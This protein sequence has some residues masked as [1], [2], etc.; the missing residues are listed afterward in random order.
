MG[1]G[2][3]TSRLE[4]ASKVLQLD[5]NIL[6]QKTAIRDL[7]GEGHLASG[8]KVMLRILEESRRILLEE[9]GLQP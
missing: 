2:P 6:R 8:A 1:N 9:L 7:E 4:L 3:D 5:L